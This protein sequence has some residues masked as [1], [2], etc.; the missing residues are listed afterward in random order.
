M[1]EIILDVDFRI[2][3][4]QKKQQRNKLRKVKGSQMRVVYGNWNQIWTISFWKSN[5]RLFS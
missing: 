2:L 1:P 4:K 3:Y 5:V